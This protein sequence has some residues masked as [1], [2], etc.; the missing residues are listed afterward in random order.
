[1]AAE[2]SSDPPS[3]RIGRTARPSLRSERER[4]KGRSIIAQH[5]RDSR[6][7]PDRVVTNARHALRVTRRQ[8]GPSGRPDDVN[9]I[10]FATRSTTPSNSTRSRA[11]GAPVDSEP[12]VR[13]SSAPIDHARCA[14]YPGGNVG[15]VPDVRSSGAVR[16]NLN[17]SARYSGDASIRPGRR[18][19]LETLRVRCRHLL[20]VRRI[21]AG[22]Q[23]MPIDTGPARGRR[24][25]P[26]GVEVNSW[27]EAPCS[28]R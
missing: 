25:P 11:R 5:F 7:G 20:K 18:H 9:S 27:S 23:A 2:R 1:M 6:G 15:A 19:H 26:G 10:D 13:S 3:E 12:A 22:R 17:D 28:R 14:L 16:A 4:V 21:F 8:G 24:T